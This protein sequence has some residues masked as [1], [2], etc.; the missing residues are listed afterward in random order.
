MIVDELR[1]C[2]TLRTDR[3]F[4]WEVC[5]FI[6]GGSLS[7]DFIIKGHRAF[8]TQQASAA[9]CDTVLQFLGLVQKQKGRALARPSSTEQPTRKSELQ[10]VRRTGSGN[11]SSRS[12]GGSSRRSRG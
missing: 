5:V 3:R 6:A 7:A 1:R 12:R 2:Y 4:D 9:N 8:S 11:G 10:R